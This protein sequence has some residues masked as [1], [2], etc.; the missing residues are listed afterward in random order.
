MSGCYRKVL[1]SERAMAAAM[2]VLPSY[3][4]AAAG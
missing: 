1:L 2:A 4:A 3:R